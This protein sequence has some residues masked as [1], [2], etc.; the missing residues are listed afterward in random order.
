M[1]A[2]SWIKWSSIS[3]LLS[4]LAVLVTLVFLVVQ[5]RQNTE[6][7]NAQLLATKA[8]SRAAI[9]EM[10]YTSLDQLVANP[11][12]SIALGTSEKLSEE[13]QQQ[14]SDWLVGFWGTREFV[15]L[16]Y[17]DGT[18]DQ[19][20]FEAI[21]DERHFLQ[22]PRVSLWWDESAHIAYDPEFVELINSDYRY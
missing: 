6:A 22:L 7:I 10:V 21:I 1:S 12:I 2:N 9:W 16:Q 4:S 3:E 15:W 20:T 13:E 19:K 8:E 18:I 14:V 5:T 11:R 17:Q